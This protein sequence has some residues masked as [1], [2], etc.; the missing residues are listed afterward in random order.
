MNTLLNTGMSGVLWTEE[1][2][3][4]KRLSEMLWPRMLAVAER[5]WHRA[6]WEHL[7]PDDS[8]GQRQRAEDWTHFANTVGYRE[9]ERLQAM[10]V[11]GYL[12]P[13]GVRYVS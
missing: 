5:A 12:P 10:G 6:S 7:T 3:T 13:P 9:M 1:V 11:H 8:E 4:E 2:R